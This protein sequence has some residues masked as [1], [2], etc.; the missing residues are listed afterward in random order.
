L[1]ETDTRA[2]D[3]TQG[4]GRAHLL[5]GD[6]AYLDKVKMLLLKTVSGRQKD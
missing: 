1:G 6:A 4:T 3:K 5:D 2:I